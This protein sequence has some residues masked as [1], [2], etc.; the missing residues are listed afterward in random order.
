[1]SQFMEYR[2]AVKLS[3]EQLRKMIR[4]RSIG[5]GLA[6]A[7]APKVQCIK[8]IT[9]HEKFDPAWRPNKPKPQPTPSSAPPKPVGSA[10]VTINTDTHE[11]TS[12]NG[13]TVG[14]TK[15]P[16]VFQAQLEPTNGGNNS[17]PKN[18]ELGKMLASIVQEHIKV[19]N[20]D[21]TEVEKIIKR[22]VANIALPTTLE[23][24]VEDKTY[25]TTGI[26][27]AIFEKLVK[28][29]A[30]RENVWLAGPAGGGKTTCCKH[31]AEALGLPFYAKSFGLHTPKS[32]IFGQ[33]FADGI[34]I[35]TDF[36]KAY[37]EGGLF[38]GDEWD[39]ANPNLQVQL[40]AAIE[41]GFCSFPDKIV[42]RH[43]DFIMFVGCN[44]FGRGA[45]S[46]YVGRQ[47]QDAAAI[48]RW[49]F[50]EFNY[51]ERLEKALSKNADWVERVQKI[52]KTIADMKEK[53]I[54]S[55]RASIKGA[56][57]LAAGFLQSDVEDMVIWKGINR[58]VKGRILAA[59]R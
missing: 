15:P 12:V 39:A 29:A 37:E 34:Y 27:H 45:D 51:D 16:V 36:R 59:I 9:G 17:V 44:T 23:V 52:R 43:K 2:E 58:E 21:M 32:E 33:R 6:V 3:T 46:A 54:V 49:V 42:E 20:L 26:R 38:L 14:T 4:E 56:K 11:I 18:E 5:S 57:L 53:V 50:V 22:E 30:L 24:K 28:L 7:L 8:W 19:N 25:I 41:N 13:E 48:D 31:V 10:S 1:M 35:G 55:P 40:N 47:Q